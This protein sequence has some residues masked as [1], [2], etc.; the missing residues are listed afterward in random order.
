VLVGRTVPEVTDSRRRSVPDVAAI[1]SSAYAQLTIEQRA[2]LDRFMA[3]LIAEV[4]PEFYADFPQFRPKEG[5]STAALTE[6]IVQ[7]IR[8][9]PKPIST[10]EV[11]A[12]IAAADPI[13]A[14]PSRAQS[15]RTLLA[16]L[17]VSKPGA[18]A[19]WRRVARGLYWRHVV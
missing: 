7:I 14:T 2:D 4:R 15:I 16:T 19:R 5:Q 1:V 3:T 9:S 10:A 13:G 11:I 8:S 6:Q 12:A 17:C 18:P